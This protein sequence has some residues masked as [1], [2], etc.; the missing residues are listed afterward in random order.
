MSNGISNQYIH[1]QVSNEHTN[2]RTTSSSSQQNVPVVQ[3]TYG[4]DYRSGNSANNK[5][6]NY[7]DLLKEFLQ[8]HNIK[9]DSIKHIILRY[10][11]GRSNNINTMAL[12]QC[13]ELQ[14]EL[15]KYIEFENE[16][17]K[18]NLNIQELF[19]TDNIF[20][21]SVDGIKKVLKGINRK[22]FDLSDSE[23]AKNII[24]KNYY[25]AVLGIESDNVSDD[26]I[27]NFIS[28]SKT[29]VERMSDGNGKITNIKEAQKKVL[30]YTVALNYNWDNVDD[31]DKFNSNNSDNLI[32]RLQKAGLLKKKKGQYTEEEIKNACQK[33]FQAF[34]Y[35]KRPKTSN[36]NLTEEEW[37]IKLLR[38]TI[39]KLIINTYNDCKS[40][41]R[42]YL[43]PIIQGIEKE[44]R[45]EA[46]TNAFL[47]TNGDSEAEQEL[48]EMMVISKALPECAEIVIRKTISKASKE[49][50][51]NFTQ[52]QAEKLAKICKEKGLDYEAIINKIKNKLDLSGEESEV[53][54]QAGIVSAAIVGIDENKNIDK[55]SGI[56]IGAK[57]Y[58]TVQNSSEAGA[59]LLLH[60]LEN[61]ISN[62]NLPE[63][64]K[65]SIE[66]FIN[67]ITNNNYSLFKENNNCELNPPVNLEDIKNNNHNTEIKPQDS[68][69][70]SEAQTAVS[71]LQQTIKEQTKSA[72]G[73][74]EKFVVIERQPIQPVKENEAASSTP[75]TTSA[76]IVNDLLQ[77]VQTISIIDIKNYSIGLTPLLKQFSA[78]ATS[79]QNHI[80]TRLESRSEDEQI[81]S[82]DQMDKNSDKVDMAL[83][84]K[85]SS[86]KLEELHL[87]TNARKN[88]ELQEDVA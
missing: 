20:T 53:L 33:Y 12:N 40:S 86:D 37:R 8:E 51:A 4:N 50:A 78:L 75:V 49:V 66:K 61:Q 41:E 38:Q 5:K 1:E 14:L 42:K 19:N 47:L 70:I 65:L 32:S 17:K 54:N 9:S 57:A 62:K 69:N 15:E 82:I 43:I 73:N 74:E 84:L 88:L 67:T 45:S 25:C 29:V 85:I 60:K 52:E 34:K 22:Q 16:I 46:V 24:A 79:V 36:S 55:Q 87:D 10:T 3:K 31:F 39:G 71:E 56:K 11:E 28:A 2:S 63:D 30:E 58:G 6:K 35:I 21:L 44:Y 13:H 64:K 26:N 81:T 76:T 23:K 48:A 59:R 7:L 27:K 72:N 77:N 68:V 18:Y 83:N 80:K